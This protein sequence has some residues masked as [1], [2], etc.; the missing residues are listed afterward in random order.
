MFDV[1]LGLERGFRRGGVFSGP[2]A[3]RQVGQLQLRLQVAGH[4]L[5]RQAD[6]DLRP[7]AAR[8]GQDD[9]HGAHGLD[10]AGRLD[11]RRQG[12]HQRGRR[13]DAQMVR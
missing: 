3:H 10:Q 5:E 4:R 7:R 6:P 13:Q 2:Q 9:D 8:R 11:G 1:F 12:A